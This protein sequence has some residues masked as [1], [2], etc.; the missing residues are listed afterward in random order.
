[1]RLTPII[2]D[3][4]EMNIAS[5]EKKANDD[6]NVIPVSLQKHN[7][8]LQAVQLDSMVAPVNLLDT[9]NRNAEYESL[10]ETA[11]NNVIRES[12]PSTA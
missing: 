7:L 4:A 2:E 10:Y 11:T 12:I 9:L 8:E 1:L 5:S 6:Y 3:F